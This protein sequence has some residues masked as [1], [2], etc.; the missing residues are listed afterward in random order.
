MLRNNIVFFTYWQCNQFP[1]NLVAYNKMYY[2]TVSVALELRSS[3]VWWFWLRVSGEI[4]VKRLTENE[5]I[6]RLDWGW[7]TG[8]W[9]EVLLPHP[10]ALPLGCVSVFM[11]WQLVFPRMSYPREKA[12]RSSQCLV[13]PDREVP[14]C[15]P[16][17]FLIIRSRSLSPACIQRMAN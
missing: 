1:Q 10:M 6:W 15:H 5:V 3:L 7:R 8:C 17:H 14:Y 4:W 9:Q 12:R 16:Y 11:T 2:L 13:P